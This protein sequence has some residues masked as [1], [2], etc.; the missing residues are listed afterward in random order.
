MVVKAAVEAMGHELHVEFYPWQ[1]AVM[2][3]KIKP[4]YA[5][6][7]PEYYFESEDIIF[8]LPIGTGPLGF[9]ENKSKPFTWSTLQDLKAVKLG[10]ISGYANTDE[11]DNMIASGEIQV[12][13]VIRD[14]QNLYKVANKRIPLAVIDSNVFAYLVNTNSKLREQKNLLQMNEKILDEKKLFIAFSN[15]KV[16]KKWK[17]IVDEGIEKIDVNKIMANYFSDIEGAK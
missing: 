7:F 8:S 11:L 15:D 14:T 13:A 3:A 16:G 12:E 2:L 1:R 6:Y 9:V 17:K 4:K 10:V 5:G